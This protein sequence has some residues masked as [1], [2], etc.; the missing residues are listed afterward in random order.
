MDAYRESIL[1]ELKETSPVEYSLFKRADIAFSQDKLLLTLED[2]VFGRE[3]GGEL[4]RILEKIYNERTRRRR[5]AETVRRRN[6]VWQYRWRRFRRE[7]VS[8]CR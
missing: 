7:R 1:L 6:N 2:T 5:R 3:K 8:P 4:A